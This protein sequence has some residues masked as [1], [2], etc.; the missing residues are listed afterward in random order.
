MQNMTG[1]RCNLSKEFRKLKYYG[2]FEI[3]VV[4]KGRQ[5]KMWVV[6]FRTREENMEWTRSDMMHSLTIHFGY[7]SSVCSNRSVD[8]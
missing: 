5:G 2:K 6:I 1:I 3:A 8:I 4:L 7:V